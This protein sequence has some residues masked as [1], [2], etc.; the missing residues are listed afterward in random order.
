MERDPGSEPNARELADT[1]RLV[2]GSGVRAIFAEPQYPAKSAG[3][4]RQ[5]TG[6]PVSTLDPAA[7]GD[8]DPARAR[9]SYLRTME[10]N[11]RV[12]TAALAD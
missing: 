5:E 11:L 4:I 6:V 8:P 1:I 9:D 7:T 3:I 10:Q 2:R 12:L